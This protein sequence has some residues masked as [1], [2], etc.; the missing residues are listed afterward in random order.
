MHRLVICFA[1][2][3]LAATAC[4]SNTEEQA[5]PSDRDVRRFCRDG[6]ALVEAAAEDPTSDDAAGAFDDLDEEVADQLDVTLRDVDPER[7][8]DPADIAEVFVDA[9][10]D[11]DDFETALDP[12]TGET[13]PDDTEPDDTAPPVDTA[14]DDTAPAD[15][16]PD[17]TTPAAPPSTFTPIAVPTAALSPEVAETIGEINL[18]DGSDPVAAFARLGFD[19]LNTAFAYPDGGY[20]MNASSG[21]YSTAEFETA[22]P[23]EV[24]A[25]YSSTF[26]VGPGDKT[27]ILEAMAAGIE[28]TADGPF[29][30]TALE[31]AGEE[32]PFALR[33][34]G[35]ATQFIVSVDDDST[36]TDAKSVTV[37]AFY[38][39]SQARTIPA[40]GNTLIDQKT[41]ELL[42]LA[43]NPKY[44]IASIGVYTADAKAHYVDVR[45]D[46]SALTLIDAMSLCQVPML[47]TENDP[48]S[49]RCTDQSGS[50]EVTFFSDSGTLY[51]R[52]GL[53]S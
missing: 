27:A 18:I 16:T 52:I 37:S 25:G 30:R 29:E 2:I 46:E 11:A 40:I 15:T 47:V 7:N 17:D 39:P 9:G 31:E 38:Q 19:T 6:A 33:L 34:I 5:A 10:C 13:T 43:P 45:Y 4:S 53:V 1:A 24:A 51:A 42:A 41:A 20:L 21:Y 3:T 8:D 12:G 35:P 50:T 22:V 44:W 28:A 32:I 14:P 36:F 23:Y 48:T 26:L 49:A